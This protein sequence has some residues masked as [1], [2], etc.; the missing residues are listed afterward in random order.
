MHVTMRRMRVTGLGGPEPLKAAVDPA[1]SAALETAGAGHVPFWSPGF[2]LL[3]P[4][5]HV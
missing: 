5:S 1:L 4:R 2:S 3:L